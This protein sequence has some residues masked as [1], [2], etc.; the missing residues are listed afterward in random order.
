MMRIIALIVGAAVLLLV[1]G[2][3]ALS[4]VHALVL[5]FWVVLFV[6][7]GVGVFRVARWS[8]RRAR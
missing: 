6:M 5:A 8:S 1:L 4:V 7:L 2:W 3:L